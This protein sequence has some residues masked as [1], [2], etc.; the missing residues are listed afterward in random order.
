ERLKESEREEM[1]ESGKGTLEGVALA[2]PALAQALEYQVR[3]ARVGFDW[4]DVQGV[5]AKITE[6]VE[7]VTTAPDVESRSAEIGD[8]LFTVVNLA[9]WYDVD[10]ESALREANLR[11]RDR[12]SNVEQAAKE[13]GLL[14]SELTLDE[15]NQLWQQ[16]RK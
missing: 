6:E 3:A 2:L 8:L 13:R 14:L 9:R 15:M 5:L 16:V 1:G 10:A 7:E 11:F 4:P 12:F